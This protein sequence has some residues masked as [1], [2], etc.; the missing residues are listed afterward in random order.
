MLAVIEDNLPRLHTA[1]KPLLGEAGEVLPRGQPVGAGEFGQVGLG[2][3]KLHV[4]PL[5]DAKGVLQCAGVT[6]EEHLHFPR[7]LVVELVGGKAHLAVLAHGAPRL[8]TGQ[9]LLHVGVGAA[10]VVAVVGSH[11]GEVTFFGQADEGG[12]DLPLLGK[13]VVLHLN[14]VVPCPKDLGHSQ[15]GGLR[16]LEIPR[17]E[18]LG[19]VTRQAGRQGDQTLVVAAQQ[20]HI[21]PGTAVKALGKARRDQ[22]H[23]VLVALHVFAEEDEMVIRPLAALHT[24]LVEAGA[25][26]DVDLTADDGL[27][28]CLLAGLVEGDCAVQHAVIRNGHGI[29]AALLHT[30]GKVGYT[31]R[32]VQKAVFGVEVKMD[33]GAH[34]RSP[35]L[36]IIW[37]SVLP[38]S[39]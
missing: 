18:S 16:S 13:A 17:Q 39:G 14:V 38:V 34:G 28:A 9:H 21:H 5:G 8:D 29:V 33:E 1:R 27:D 23:E 15:G 2:E 30:G 35:F 3:I 24:R 6:G 32:A 26:R 7:V 36:G 4:T 12:Y 19:D 31:A 10:E 20:L 37:N 22:G 25:G 11:Q